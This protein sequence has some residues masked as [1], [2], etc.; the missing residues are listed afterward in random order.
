MF[1][2]KTIYGKIKTLLVSVGVV[3]FLLFLVLVFYKSKLEKQIIASSKDQ[4]S[5]EVNSLF[6][7]NSSFMVQ[8]VSFYSFW[9]EFVK[10][11]AENNKKW[12]IENIT[13]ISFYKYDYICVYNKS[14]DI[15]QELSSNDFLPKGIIPKDAV[16]RLNKARYSHFYL[17]TPA[18]LMEVSAA[19][20]LPMNDPEHNKTEPGGY[21]VVARR[22][23]QQMLGELSNIS[24]SRIEIL[25]NSA[26]VPV[27]GN[28]SINAKIDLPDWG[29]N[30]I[31]SIVFTR[32]LDL[33]F[34]ATQDIM[35]VIL[36]FVIITLLFSDFIARRC[37]NR[38]LRLVT[39]ILKTD[40]NE[41]IQDLK[42]APAEYG[43]IGAL[44]EAYV[45]QKEELKKAKEKAEESDR[46]KSAF[47][48][49]MSHE[50]RT[51]MN[52]IVGFS[53]LIEFETDQVKKH[54]YVKII[55]SSSTNLLNLIVGIVDLSKIETGAM[56]L[57]YSDFHV[58]EVFSELKEVYTVELIK[59]EKPDVKLNY[60]ISGGDIIT[61]SDPHLLKQAISNLLAN[62]VKFTSEGAINFECIKLKDELIFSVSDTG[63]GIP[64]E[65]QKKIFDRFIKFDYHGLN[66]EGTGIGLSL[67]EKIVNLLNGKIWLKSRYGEG[68]SFFIS[69]P[70]MPPTAG[71]IPVSLRKTQKKLTIEVSG[72]RK[73]ILVVEDDKESYLLIHEILRPLNIDIHHVSDGEEAVEYMKNNPDTAMVLM[74]MKLPFMNGDDATMAI[75]KFNQNT[76]IIAQT[77]YAMIGDKEKAINAGCNDYVTKPLESKKLREL[78]THHLR[79]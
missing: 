70:Y 50:I 9:D 37:I 64:D 57:N 48:A 22:L 63:T 26:P 6:R 30:T 73:T 14:Y 41:S 58:S 44:F 78:I 7:S 52:A 4:F 74:D 36:A 10:A 25:P 23:D 19:S 67:V 55:Q 35:I 61:C 62:A 1:R 45:L 69:I 47:L 46:L 72:V 31:S 38:P 60:N 32:N 53:E 54:Q 16:I 28:N 39:D 21:L 59:R 49:N 5:N 29:G 8:T 76:F 66:N 68:S 27:S 75:R 2:F 34:K 17:T 15:V 12:I 71:T 24:G 77:A 33:N 79:N 43:H 20:V 42:K 40:S 13:I 18:G 11:I 3:F 56:Q 51:P 65:D